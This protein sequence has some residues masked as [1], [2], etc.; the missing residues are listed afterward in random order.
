MPCILA[1]IIFSILGIFSATHRQLAKEAFGCVFN[2][3]KLQPCDTG[4]DTKVKAKVLGNL[5]NRS[6]KA[7]KFVNKHFELLAWSFMII[8]TV[9]TTYFAYGLVN[10]YRYGS[11]AGLNET[12]FCVFDPAGSHN[13]ISGLT[14]QECRL[15]PPDEDDLSLEEVDLSLFPRQTNNSDQ[16]L[17]FIGCFSCEY[18]RR[19]YPD[20][21]RLIDTYSPNLTFAHLPTIE[22]TNFISAYNYC[23]YQQDPDVYWQFI[24]YLFNLDTIRITDEVHLTRYLRNQGIDIEELETCLTSDEAQEIVD[25][26]LTELGKI[27]VY[28]TPTIF[29]DERP[30]VGPKPFRVYRRLLNQSWW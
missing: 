4:F 19:A 29:F 10:Y 16:E 3:I 6:P 9:S 18:T 13:Q 21:K 14:T 27:G 26:Q 2:R 11:C 5:I 25:V 24:D 1:F 23:T 17:I 22:E 12:G 15:N 30:A 28:G 20:I 8:F 7:A